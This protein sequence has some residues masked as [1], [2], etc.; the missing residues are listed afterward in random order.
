MIEVQPGAST[1]WKLQLGPRPTQDWLQAEPRLWRL[2][3]LWQWRSQR[4]RTKVIPALPRQGKA[5]RSQTYPTPELVSKEWIII[6]IRCICAV[7]RVRHSLHLLKRKPIE[8]VFD[9]SR[10]LES[11]FAGHLLSNNAIGRVGATTVT[12][13]LNHGIFQH[14][15]QHF[16]N[17]TNYT[18]ACTYISLPCVWTVI[19]HTGCQCQI[20]PT[21]LTEISSD[22]FFVTDKKP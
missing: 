13:L 12:T 17:A 7:E 3:S 14:L 2:P 16:L 4:W 6:T 21:D 15:L 20:W 10:Y 18:Q 19:V 8:A 11:L 5:A 9:S 22:E 1:R